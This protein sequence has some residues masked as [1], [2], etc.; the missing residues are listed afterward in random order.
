MNFPNMNEMVSI[1]DLMELN[2]ALRKAGT[3]GYQT[4]AD[5][6]VGGTLSPLVPQSLEGTLASATFT[7]KQLSIWPRIPKKPV[8]QT[9]HEYTVVNEHGM[10]L[11]PFIAEGGGGTTNSSDYTRQA[12][13]I[14][15]M[16]ERRE[17]TDVATMVGLIG[18]NANALAEET[19]RGTIS[20]MQ[21]VERQILHGNVDLNANGFDGI[22]EQVRNGG[23]VTDLEGSPVTSDLL[24]EL[25]GT[26][27]SAP[28]FGNPDTIYLE[29]KVLQDLIR[30]T[31]AFGRHDQVKVSDGTKVT[32][33]ARNIEIMSSYGP[34]PVQPAPFLFTAYPAPTAGSGGTSAPSTPT[35][36]AQPVHAAGLTGTSGWLAAD[37]GDYYWKMVAVSD[38]GYSAPVTSAQTA[39]VVD[40]KIAIDMDDAAAQAADVPVKYY[41]VYR[42]AKDGAVGTCKL[43][44]EVP[45]NALGGAAGTYFGDLNN[46]KPNTTK[47]LIVQHD[48]TIMEFVR[49]LDFLRRPLA[50]VATTKPFLLM[51]FGAPVVKVPSKCWLLDNIGVTPS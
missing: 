41:R 43:L 4:P 1:G 51:L 24:Q 25:L 6:T 50:E 48:P 15:Y 27:Q 42:S 40:Q 13:Q 26:L 19:E 10:D 2:K 8:S 47:S 18:P 28:Y 29:P 16:A 9:V 35:I 31:V 44:L 22:I 37:A 46:V 12:V 23:N 11:D 21:K 17:V 34:I 3:I 7:M 38:G 30:Q 20:L 32:F 45:V 39:V 14:K 36:N 5:T 49:L 33:G